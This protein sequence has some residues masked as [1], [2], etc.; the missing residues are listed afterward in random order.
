MNQELINRMKKGETPFKYRCL[1]IRSFVPVSLLRKILVKIINVLNTRYPSARMYRNDDWYEHDEYI[2]GEEVVEWLFLTGIVSNDD[3]LYASRHG[4]DDVRWAFFPEHYSFLL[5]YIVL[6]EDEYADE[7]LIG[8]WGSFDFCS[9][10]DLMNDIKKSLP[11]EYDCILTDD[12]A[13]AYF[14]KR[15]LTV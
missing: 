13:S 12:S 2:S 5:R 14:G 11:D 7:G 8:I 10:P 1:G 9:D 6:D 4:D 15:S 3:T